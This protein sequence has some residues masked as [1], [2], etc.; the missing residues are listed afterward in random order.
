MTRTVG[1]ATRSVRPATRVLSLTRAGPDL[2]RPSGEDAA[3]RARGRAGANEPT[4][5]AHRQRR[6][7]RDRDTGRRQ[8]LQHQYL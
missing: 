6:R 5:V 3:D 2:L 7:G 8:Y 1:P 4:G